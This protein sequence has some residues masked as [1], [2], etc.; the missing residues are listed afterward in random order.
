M[1]MYTQKYL[2]SSISLPLSFSL[3]LS[4]SLFF[5][6]SSPLPCCLYLLTVMRVRRCERLS[7]S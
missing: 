3:S 4:L 5:S 6:L 1:E 7:T 2:I